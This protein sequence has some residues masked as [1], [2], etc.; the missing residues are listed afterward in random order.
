MP[1]KSKNVKT[2]NKKVKKT[3][4][5][6]DKTSNK[7]VKKTEKKVDKTS[8]KKV[9]KTSNKKVDKTS[10]KKVDKTSNKK[11]KKTEKK[12]DKPS[13]KKVDKPSDKKVKKTD[14]KVE[15]EEEDEDIEDDDDIDFNIEEEDFFDE[16]NFQD[17]DNKIKFHIFDPNTYENE[18]HKEIIIAHP[19]NRKTS[20]I[21]TK[22]E[23]TDVVSNR[24][25]QIENG[26]KIFVDIKNESDP[27]VMAEMEIKMKQCP[28]AVR[29]MLSNNFAEIWE[30]NE[31]IVPY[32][33]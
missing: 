15:F 28:L 32:L 33:K 25:K 26:S 6:V 27:I 21:I 3:E 23:F 17:F 19:Q 1:P 22:F 14:K 10:N 5:K 4:K 11:V 12:V 20:E 16:K 13:D 7:K 30:V 29:R 9:D 2:S 18:L 24:A 8:N 31:M